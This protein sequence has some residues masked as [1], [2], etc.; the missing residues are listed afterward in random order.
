MTS[1]FSF[2][3]PLTSPFLHTPPRPSLLAVLHWIAAYC[4]FDLSAM[5]AKPQYM[6]CS[7][8]AFHTDD[9]TCPANTWAYWVVPDKAF[10][11]VGIISS[12]LSIPLGHFLAFPA[13]RRCLGWC[14]VVCPVVPR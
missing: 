7:L 12:L 13:L 4:L 10:A 3:L 6:F 8:L 14:C 2:L 9:S 1:V 5:Q 11:L